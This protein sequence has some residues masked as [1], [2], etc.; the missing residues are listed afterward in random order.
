[1]AKGPG[2]NARALRE[3][4][5]RTCKPGPVPDKSGLHHLSGMPLTEHLDRPT[6]RLGAGRSST[7]PLAEHVGRP[8]WSFSPWGLPCRSAR[9]ERGGL[10]LHPPKRAM[11]A[12]EGGHHPF[13]LACRLLDIGGLLSVAL[14]VARPSPAEP[15]PV[16]KHGALCCPDFPPTLLQRVS[17]G[18]VRRMSMNAW[19]PGGQLQWCTM[20]ITV[21]P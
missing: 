13:T 6:R 21:A 17:D 12:C 16:R 3:N 10:L 4:Y 2:H 7:L 18:A 14:S 15:L 9:T 8:I 20:S 1:M 5:L 19:P 11:S